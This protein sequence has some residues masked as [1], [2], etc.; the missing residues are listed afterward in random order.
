M[1]V[2]DLDH[3]VDRYSEEPWLLDSMLKQIL[4]KEAQELVFE[5][6]PI[7]LSELDLFEVK[8][9]LAVFYTFRGFPAPGAPAWSEC[10]RKAGSRELITADG[11]RRIVA[12]IR[13][14]KREARREAKRVDPSL[15]RRVDEKFSLAPLKTQLEDLI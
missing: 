7:R 5:K 11:V 14:R 15:V 6:L 13:R 10:T 9:A 2:V 3:L 4:D 1:S 12:Y 8:F